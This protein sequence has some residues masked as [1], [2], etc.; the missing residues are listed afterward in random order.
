MVFGASMSIQVREEPGGVI[1]SQLIGDAIVGGGSMAGDDE[2]EGS[3]GDEGW[4]GQ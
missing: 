2:A 1:A 4:Q 3:G